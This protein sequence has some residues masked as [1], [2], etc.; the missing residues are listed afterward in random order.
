MNM[1]LDDRIKGRQG[2]GLVQLIH[3]DGKGKTTSSLGQAMRCA[4]SGKKVAI[5]FFD[6]GGD[7]HYSERNILNQI[8]N[9]DYFITG[10]DRIDKSGRFDF[11]ITDFDRAEAARGMQIAGECFLKNYD[12][13]ILDEINSTCA[14][15]MIDVDDV[16]E[17]LSNKPNQTEVILTGRNPHKKLVKLAHLISNVHSERHYFSSGVK[18][19]EGL[20]F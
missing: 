3:G 9:I 11:S 6:K 1:E 16:V 5:I 13:I 17:I 14:L 4:G 18:A 15:G 8:K 7:G 10:R 12:L 2:Y 19:R 20:D